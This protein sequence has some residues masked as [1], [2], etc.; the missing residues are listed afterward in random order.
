MELENVWRLHSFIEGI[1]EILR[2]WFEHEVRKLAE[3][4]NRNG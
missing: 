3:F 1:F 2:D 4:V